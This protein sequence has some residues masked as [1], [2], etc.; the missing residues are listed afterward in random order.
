MYER[1][2]RI[3][4]AIEGKA[5]PALVKEAHTLH[6]DGAFKKKI[7]QVVTGIVIHDP[8]GWKIYQEGFLLRGVKSNNEAKYAALIKGLEKVLDLGISKLLVY[9]DAMLVIK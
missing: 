9:G 3:P 8:A 5:Q 7:E 6:F 1:K 4:K 2:V